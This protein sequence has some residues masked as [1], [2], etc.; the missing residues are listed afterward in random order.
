[1]PIENLITKIYVLVHDYLKTE[2]TLRKRG[3][4]PKLTD[5]EV[6]TMEIVGEFLGHGADKRIYDYFRTHWK[7]LFPKLGCRTT[8]TRQAAN[9]WSAKQMMQTKLAK[10]IS[11]ED[12]LFLTDG[13]PIPT[14][15]RKRVTKKNPF[16]GIGGFGYC[17]AKDFNYFGFKGHFVTNRKGLVLGFTIA[18]ANI[19][20][21][22]V[23]P[24][25]V[26]GK[27]GMIIADKGLIRPMLTEL[28]AEQG[29]NLQ[30][31]LR[32]NMND[33]RPKKLVNTMMNIRRL[34]ETV[35]SQ[36][37]ERLNMQS[38]RAK[39]LWHITAK[40]GRKVLTHTVAFLFAGSLKFD[41]ILA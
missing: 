30:T 21:R 10:Q 7:V 13:F 33:K 4:K 32:K 27:Q 18:A 1:M 39:D 19:D 5:A 9:L 12:D 6:I 14:C 25:V 36:F 34:V 11:P 35:L 40:I 29:L 22:D 31:P 3:P 20:E 8:F 37:S 41:S 17:A 15:N 2:Q 16:L 24:E 26:V 38:I 23:L 28:L